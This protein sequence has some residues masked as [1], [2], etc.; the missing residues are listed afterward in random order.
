MNFSLKRPSST[1]EFQF[2]TGDC[3]VTVLLAG[4]SENYTVTVQS[5]CSHCA[6]LVTDGMGALQCRREKKTNK[7][8]KMCLP[9]RIELCVGLFYLFARVDG[10]KISKN[11]FQMKSQYCRVYHMVGCIT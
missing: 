6:A 3:V 11:I 8:K 2:K 5:P 9:R 4:V 1:G 7:R 10:R